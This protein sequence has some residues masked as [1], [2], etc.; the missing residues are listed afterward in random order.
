MIIGIIG[1]TDVD[2][3]RLK[4]VEDRKKNDLQKHTLTDGESGTSSV[5]CVAIW[6]MGAFPTKYVCDRSPKIDFNAD[7]AHWKYMGLMWLSTENKW[8]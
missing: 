8:D 1:S 2:I 3:Y 7:S 5:D 6:P 4:P